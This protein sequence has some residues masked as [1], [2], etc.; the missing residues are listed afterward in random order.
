[1]V[2]LLANE[3]DT[4]S[5]NKLGQVLIYFKMEIVK[6]ELS[7]LEKDTSEDICTELDQTGF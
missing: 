2:V 5:K 4:D 3:F 6:S 7:Y 1:M